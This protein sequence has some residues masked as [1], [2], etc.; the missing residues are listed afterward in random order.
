M[1]QLDA[2][3]LDLEAQDLKGGDR[4]AWLHHFAALLRLWRQLPERAEKL[5]M[6]SRIIS[7]GRHLQVLGAVLPAALVQ[8]LTEALKAEDAPPASALRHAL[9]APPTRTEFLAIVERFDSAV[10]KDDLKT[11]LSALRILAEDTLEAATR[12]NDADLFLAALGV[13]A[14]PVLSLTAG[15]QKI[16]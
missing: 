1:W 16:R 12:A 3:M 6:L 4:T 5:P 15:V 9:T 11:Q 2:L 8:E 10:R 13:L 14:Q 7:I